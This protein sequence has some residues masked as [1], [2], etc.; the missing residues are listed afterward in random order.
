MTDPTTPIGPHAQGVMEQAVDD[1][2]IVFDPKTERYYTLNRTAREVWELADGTR[3]AGDI[4]A[5]LAERYD[6]DAAQVAPD[7]ADIIAHLADA[8]L[9]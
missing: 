6:A 3:T 5:V 1:D 2:L 8:G 7:V 4:A 9:L